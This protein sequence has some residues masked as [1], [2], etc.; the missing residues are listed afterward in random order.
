MMRKETEESAPAVVGPALSGV[1]G[2]R[3]MPGYSDAKPDAKPAAAVKPLRRQKSQIYDGNS[4]RN[5]KMV[6]HPSFRL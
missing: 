3:R 5:M 2:L 6:S 4:A 1:V